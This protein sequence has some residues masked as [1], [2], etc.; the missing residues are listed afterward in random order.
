MIVS[1]GISLGTPRYAEMS[2][3]ELGLS[4]EEGAREKAARSLTSSEYFCILVDSN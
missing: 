2:M 4:K 1:T 3:E